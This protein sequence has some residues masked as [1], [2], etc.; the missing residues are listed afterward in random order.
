MKQK[1]DYRIMNNHPDNDRRA[2]QK[3]H[4]K[5][6][7]NIPTIIALLGV[8]LSAIAGYY[9]LRDQDKHSDVRITAMQVE[10]RHSRE[11]QEQIDKAQDE[12]SSQIISEII[13]AK[14]EFREQ[15]SQTRMELKEEQR[16]TRQILNAIV[17]SLGSDKK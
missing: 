6:E 1:I 8:S 9:D 16:E 3:W 7:V 11:L 14:Q 15:H 12:R 13:D 17:K 5:K 4:V 10:F 2:P